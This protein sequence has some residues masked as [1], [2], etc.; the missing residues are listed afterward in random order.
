M[1]VSVAFPLYLAFLERAGRAQSTLDV[2]RSI[3]RRWIGP[4]LDDLPIDELSHRHAAAVID[5]M[6]DATPKAA[7]VA[8][9]ILRGLSGWA[10]DE[11]L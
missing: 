6:S 7:A 1:T 8:G 9:S 11:D 5:A 3:H 10:A 2:Y 4:A